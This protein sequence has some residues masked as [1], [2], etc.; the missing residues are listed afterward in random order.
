MEIKEKE[1][2]EKW[3][4]VKK[5]FDLELLILKMENWYSLIEKFLIKFFY[6]WIIFKHQTKFLKF[7]FNI[8]KDNF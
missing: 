8:F 4:F 5:Y 1:T 3:S 7:D 2:L 6:K